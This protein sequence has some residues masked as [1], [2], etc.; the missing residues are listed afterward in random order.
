MDPNDKEPVTGELF[1]VGINDAFGERRPRIV[2]T[3][4]RVTTILEDKK[5]VERLCW[6][7]RFEFSLWGTRSQP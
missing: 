3:I 1:V 6:W 4:G 7:D 5:G 2:Q